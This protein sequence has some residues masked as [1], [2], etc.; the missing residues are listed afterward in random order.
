MEVPSQVVKRLGLNNVQKSWPLR[1]VW[2]NIAVVPLD[3]NGQMVF[4]TNNPDEGWDGTVNGVKQD[5]EVYTWYVKVVYQDKFVFH[6]Y[7]ISPQT[8]R[9]VFRKILL[10][11][12]LNLPVFPLHRD[13]H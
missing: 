8:I 4:Q 3:Q 5:M 9:V 11:P 12:F 7:C 1:D 13:R 6:L 10:H 2:P